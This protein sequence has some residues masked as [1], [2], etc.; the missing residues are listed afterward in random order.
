[1]KWTTKEITMVGLGATLMGVFSQ[2]S[3][4]LPT[5]PLTLQVFGAIILAIVLGAKRGTYAMMIYI[6]IGSIGVPVFSNFSRGLGVVIGPTGGY[7]L[8]F[9]ALAFVVG[10]AV[11]Q[12]S[13]MVRIGM[14]YCGLF[15]Q[16]A[17]GTLQ[18]KAVL[19][20]NWQ[21]AMLAGVYPF[22]IKDLILT[23]I[24]IWVGLQIKSRLRGVIG[25]TI[26]A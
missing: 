18:L 4:P 12:R 11:E 13:R 1:M 7:I 19:G 14:V 20:M 16:Y 22:I 8:G 15:I 21:E 5:V 3:I 9:I 2:L 24:A 17:I 23:G 10:K 6:L 26:N 25:E